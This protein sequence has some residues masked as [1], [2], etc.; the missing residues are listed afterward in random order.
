MADTFEIRVNGRRF[1]DWENSSVNRSID[2]NAGEFQFTSTSKIPSEYP[3][4]T[5][6]AVQI[7]INGTPKITGFA[8]STIGRG[9][10]QEGQFITISGRDNTSDLVDSSM[11]DSVKALE[12]PI[13][14]QK[15]C[16]TV[17]DA[18]GASI[19]AVVSGNFTIDEF[20][21]EVEFVADSGRGCM[22][23]LVAFARKRQVYLV[24]SGD[25]NLLIFRPGATVSTTAILNEKN[26]VKNNVLTWNVSLSHQERFNRYVVRSQDNFGF[27]NFADYSNGFGVDRTGFAVDNEIRTSRFLEIQAP[28]TQN[29]EETSQTSIELANLRTANSQEY[30][31]KLSGVKQNDGTVWDFGQLVSIRDDFADIRGTFLIK[32]IDYDID[33]KTGS[34]VMLTCVPPEAYQVRLPTATD[35]RIATKSTTLQRDTPSD[36]ARFQRS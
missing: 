32:A 18:L 33:L 1:T 20:S 13:T 24:P 30:T 27:D 19:T 2:V 12:G 6:D 26:N 9:T 8:D 11:P 36:P 21:D 3:I 22:E 34:T 4:K 7:Y 35:E 31:C 17:I 16:Q 15:L 5:G 25:G 28:E 10:K 29:D 23:F 14:L